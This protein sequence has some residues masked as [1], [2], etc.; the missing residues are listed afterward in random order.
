LIAVAYAAHWLTRPR[1]DISR[2]KRLAV[3]VSAAAVGI[4]ACLGLVLPLAI[5]AGDD[6][7]RGFF[8]AMPK[9]L[10]MAG[11]SAWAIALPIAILPTERASM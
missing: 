3:R 1:D 6:L 9:I 10:I 2:R 4:A 8:A 11:L 7:S 5:P